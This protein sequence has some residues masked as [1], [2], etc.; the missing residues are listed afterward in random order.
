M[1]DSETGAIVE[2]QQQ[3]RNRLTQLGFPAGTTANNVEHHLAEIAVLSRNFAEHT[4]PLFLSLSLEH[5]ESL[6]QLIVSIK[7]DLEQ[8]RDSL[9]DI[10]PDLMELMHYLN[11]QAP[12]ADGT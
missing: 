2:L 4:L 5:R 10:E 1:S 8:L 7:C 6:A 9:T 3:L 12:Q 11:D